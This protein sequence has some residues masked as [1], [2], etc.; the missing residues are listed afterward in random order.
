MKYKALS[1]L[2]LVSLFVI[3]MIIVSCGGSKSKSG[4]SEIPFDVLF[5]IG[6]L[7]NPLMSFDGEH[8]A[9]LSR[10][11]GVV[12]I[13]L[14]SVGDDASTI[15]TADTLYGV[16]RFMWAADNVHI[17]FLLD[18]NGNGNLRIY[19]VNIKSNEIRD[20][21]PFDE[22]R[23][24]FIGVNKNYPNEV[25]FAMNKDNPRAYDVYRLDL[26]T[27]NFVL[28]AQNPGNIVG[29]LADSQ[30]KISGCLQINQNGGYD[31]MIAD[32]AT[33]EWQ[34]LVSWNSDDILDS[35]PIGFSKDNSLIYALDA[36]DANAGRLVTI[37]TATGES[38]IVAED[39]IYNVSGVFINPDTQEIQ[40]VSFNGER[41]YSI[42][43][44]DSIRDDIAAIQKLHHG[45]YFISSRSADDHLWLVGFKNDDG[46]V[47][48]YLYDRSKKSA[49]LL[50]T[51]FDELGKY[52]LSPM[53]PF[54]STA[55]DGMTIH[56]YITFPPESDRKK[57]PTVVFVHD[58]PWVR[59]EWGYDAEAQWMANRG[60]LCLQVNFRGSTGY[61]K[62]FRNAGIKQWG[63]G[64]QD[65]LIDAVA[66]AVD[67]GYADSSRVAIM[68]T[69]YGGYA[70]LMGAARNDDV[71]TCALD[72]SGFT[73][74]LYLMNSIPAQ[75]IR[76][77][78]LYYNRVGNAE[79]ESDFL[80]SI[81]PIT[82]KDSI[83]I[84]MVI[85]HGKY[86][87][88]VPQAQVEE[89]V[90]SLNE[91]TIDN[92]FLLLDNEAHGLTQSANRIVF[93]QTAEAFLRKHLGQ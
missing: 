70:A 57:V 63:A 45:D 91:R 82:Y 12:N 7:M 81:S 20:L 51:H 35:S 41:E 34:S 39:S 49:E 8:L 38:K 52:K 2:V 40:A 86:D 19:D 25:L 73:D 90:A 55:R 6:D 84:P 1:S 80:K 66:W 71:F 24:Q 32:P 76:L 44:D 85:L 27:G 56:G 83:A 47:P 69:G 75:N 22:I 17:L 68:G 72:I 61:G 46:P 37:N 88:Q 50:F 48:F 5:G 78:L 77:K 53:E 28:E 14:R 62:K 43:F 65:D 11:D 16:Q 29:W 58:G 10:V 42:I 74:L 9:Y 30:L 3:M 31:F 87:R 23:A 60:Y 4:V 21:T 93:Y 64:M 67:Q 33:K 13:F 15:L 54:S 36:R 18:L 92:E 79:V 59:D 89:I 26:S